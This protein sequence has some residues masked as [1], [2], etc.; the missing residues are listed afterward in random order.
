MNYIDRINTEL[1]INIATAYEIALR[2]PDVKVLSKEPDAQEII[3]SSDWEIYDGEDIA[4]Q[5]VNGCEITCHVSWDGEQFACWLISINDRWL[6]AGGQGAQ[7]NSNCMTL[8]SGRCAAMDEYF[9]RLIPLIKKHDHNG[10]VSIEVVFKEGYPIYKNIY[11]GF[12]QLQ[13]NCLEELYELG[14]SELT[15]KTNNGRPMDQFVRGFVGS[16]RIHAYPYMPDLNKSLGDAIMDNEK[17]IYLWDYD[18]HVVYKK[19]K[20]ITETWRELYLEADVLK[21]YGACY[22]IDGD[23]KARRTFFRLKKDGII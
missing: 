18:S 20:N 11:F 7:L 21:K 16:M 10:F 2:T 4:I 9:N 5:K 3:S 1:S 17:K 13:K 12:T 23:V 6:L 22:R 8:F 19:G 14:S 15:L